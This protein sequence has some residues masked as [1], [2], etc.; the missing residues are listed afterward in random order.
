MGLPAERVTEQPTEIPH[1]KLVKEPRPL[2]AA[3][4]RYREALM[5]SLPNS[6]EEPIDR[7]EW[8]SRAKLKGVILT[9][10]YVGQVLRVLES[11]GN[12][13]PNLEITQ[14]ILKSRRSIYFY[15]RKFPVEESATQKPLIENPKYNLGPSRNYPIN[16]GAGFTHPHPLSP[17]EFTDR[18]V[19]KG[20]SSLTFKP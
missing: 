2:T 1:L 9:A 6:G 10:G 8:A 16:V 20:K 15:R 3:V 13:P 17:E 5:A 19:K 12:L 4:K 7:K 11:S 14:K 18:Y